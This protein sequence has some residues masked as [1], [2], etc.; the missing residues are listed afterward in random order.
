MSDKAT[1]RRPSSSSS[2]TSSLDPQ[3]PTPHRS[4]SNSMR[5][6]QQTSPGHSHRPSFTEQLRGMPPSPRGTRQLS[7]SEA[8]IRDLM[9]NPPM[10][11]SADPKFAGR[12]WQHIAVGELVQPEDLRWVE[13]D[14][15]VED[16]T[17]VGYHPEVGASDDADSGCSSSQ[18][19]AHLYYSSEPPK[20]TTRPLRL[21]TTE[22]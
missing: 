22:T 15:G 5:L 17:N 11:G 20:M 6:A 21:S 12:D 14:T 4:H 19:L 16:A 2:A 13:V 3:R 18:S 8:Q 1:A 10:A 9:N 7:M